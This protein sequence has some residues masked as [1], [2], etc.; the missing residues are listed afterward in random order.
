L[1]TI[2]A[3]RLLPH[4]I[5]RE[6]VDVGGRGEVEIYVFLSV[7][8]HCVYEYRTPA[9]MGSDRC[10]VLRVRREVKDVNPSLKRTSKTIKMLHLGVAEKGWCV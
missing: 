3:K 8:E 2:V 1:Q 7:E 5:R 10:A 9:R 6:R 4:E